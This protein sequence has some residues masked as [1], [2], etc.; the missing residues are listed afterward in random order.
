MPATQLN[1][2]SSLRCMQQGVT[3]S[4][5]SRVEY[6]LPVAVREPRLSMPDWSV[7]LPLLP[8]GSILKSITT[9]DRYYY[10]VPNQLYRLPEVRVVNALGGC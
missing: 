6:R 5:A 8:S 4:A 10:S 1:N 3:H 9:C 2:A 7:L